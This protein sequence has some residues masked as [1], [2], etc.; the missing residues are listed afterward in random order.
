MGITEMV[1]FRLI[2][3]IEEEIRY[4]YS[5]EGDETG[6]AGLISLDICKGEITVLRP[7]EKDILITSTVDGMKAI[8]DSINEMRV[9]QGKPLLT[10][11]KLPVATEESKYYCY[12]V[13]AVKK[14]IEECNNGNILVSGCVMWY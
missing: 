7:A 2:F 8:R 5:P 6:E 10:E 11:E 13:K 4:E 3:E 9:E 14:I 1:T 12:A